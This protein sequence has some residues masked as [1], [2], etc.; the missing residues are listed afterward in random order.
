MILRRSARLSASTAAGEIAGRASIGALATAGNSGRRGKHAAAAVSNSTAT[1]KTDAAAATKKEKKTTTT[2]DEPVAAATTLPRKRRRTATAVDSKP[3]SVT[4]SPTA[5]RLVT[6]GSASAGDVNGDTSAVQP[7]PPPP[8]LTQPRP[9]EPHATNAPL[10][11]PGS[12]R[13]VAAY[14]EQ[15][16]SGSALPKPTTTTGSL[17]EQACAHLIKVDPRLKAVINKYS[18]PLFTPESLAEPV[19]PFRSLASSIISQQVRCKVHCS[20]LIN[21]VIVLMAHE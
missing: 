19:D 18:C 20:I 4:T 11:S 3:P 17:L 5:V 2:A 6:D 12:S 15:A 14:S 1:G 9:A 21:I 16:A 10:L 13:V 8:P 7:Q